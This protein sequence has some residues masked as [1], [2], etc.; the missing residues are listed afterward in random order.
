MGWAN[1]GHREMQLAVCGD[2]HILAC[3]LGASILPIR[4][5]ERH[6]LC[7]RLARGWLLIG[8]GSADKDILP[9]S[10]SEEVNI[11]PDLVRG[12]SDPIHDHIKPAVLQHP[13]D[14]FWIVKIAV[15]EP[16]VLW[17]RALG[18]APIQKV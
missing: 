4:I 8:G 12:I 14:L 6:R 16:R 2:Q 11:L 9:C 3:D 7:Y 1:N 15:Q 5:V 10:I 17:H 13:F 18:L